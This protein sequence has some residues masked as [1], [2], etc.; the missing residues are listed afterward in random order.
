MPLCD[1]TSNDLILDWLLPGCFHSMHKN[2]DIILSELADLKFKVY[3][4][5]FAPT[6]QEGKGVTASSDGQ[7]GILQLT[8][9]VT[10]SAGKADGRLKNAAASSEGKADPPLKKLGQSTLAQAF[11]TSIK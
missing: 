11:C 9:E 7:F 6:Q 8:N 10:T 1:P 2:I 3:R 4:R 5:S